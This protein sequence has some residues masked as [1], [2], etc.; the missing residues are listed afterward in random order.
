[1]APARSLI[2]RHYHGLSTRC[3]MHVIYSSRFCTISFS[4]VY[5]AFSFELLSL[6]LYI[7]HM[8]HSNRPKYLL[9]AQ[10]QR[11][12]AQ[13]FRQSFL[14][15]AH[16]LEKEARMEDRHQNACNAHHPRDQ[17]LADWTRRILSLSRVTHIPSRRRN[18]CS[19]CMRR[20]PHPPSWNTSANRSS[21]F[22]S[23]I[24]TCLPSRGDYN[25]VSTFAEESPKVKTYR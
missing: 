22:P 12:N 7:Y 9:N 13:N 11:G 8:L 19:F 10:C 25:V 5:D 15:F 14:E 18:S 1:M 23:E 24:S 2:P 6:N 21:V 3:L 16:W 17:E 4:H 20:L